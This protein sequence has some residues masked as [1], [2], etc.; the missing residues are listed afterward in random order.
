MYGMQLEEEGGPLISGG[1]PCRE[2]SQ[3]AVHL[4]EAAMATSSVHTDFF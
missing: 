2:H 4:E 1:G 3:V